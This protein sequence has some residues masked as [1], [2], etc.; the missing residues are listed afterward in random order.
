MKKIL[1]FGAAAMMACAANA[2]LEQQWSH[3]MTAH[4]AAVR[5]IV[6]VNGTEVAA[7]NIAFSGGADNV[8][9]F[10]A[11][12]QM[13]KTHDVAKF[14]NDNQIGTTGEDGAFTAYTL[15]RGIDVDAVGNVIVNLGFPNATQGKE[16][17]V[18]AP[19]GTMRH[20]HCE[21]PAPGETARA[22]F[23]ACAGDINANGYLVMAMHQ[24][25]PIAVYNIYEGEQDS[26]Y[27]YLVDA[28]EGTSFTN[29]TKV[30]FP[31]KA[32]AEDAENAP[33]FFVYARGVSGVRYSDGS[34]L[35]PLTVL[36]ETNFQQGKAT[37]TG[38]AAFQV[39]GVNYIVMPTPSAAGTRTT[40]FKVVNVATGELVASHPGLL[41]NDVYTNDFS[42]W[43]NEDGT[44]SIAQLVQGKYLAMFKLT[45]GSSAIEEIA[46]ENAAVEYFNL[47]GVKVDNPEKGLFI[48]KQAG[49]ATKVVL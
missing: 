39:D 32:V 1:L 18:I 6:L 45:L 37:S 8:L 34:N 19:D 15:G 31:V 4:A 40:A 43:V 42:A 36:N 33:E 3:D 10:D 13:A 16:F 11:T 30:V 17:V 12:G 48:K 9:F 7:T 14:L 35:A 20:I 26:D 41:D 21:V 5:N 23:F 24:K 22:D 44:V 29:E 49:K 47:Q 2:Q 46:A 38:L 25:A 27:S 28:D